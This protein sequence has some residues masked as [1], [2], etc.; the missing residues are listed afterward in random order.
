MNLM[1]FRAK[2]KP[3][4]SANLEDAVTTMFAA[5]EAAQPRGCEV[6]LVTAWRQHHLHHP[7]G[8][9][10]SPG[11][12]AHSH[13]RVWS[14][15]RKNPGLAGGADRAR[16]AHRYRLLQLVLRTKV[17]IPFYSGSKPLEITGAKGANDSC[18]PPRQHVLS[19]PTGSSA[20]I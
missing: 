5:I 19:A 11:E 7:A 15:S 10:E 8:T 12:P 9:Q 1:M 14:V 4:H 6:R 17:A 18:R 16:A 20:R 13:P 3:E 2:V